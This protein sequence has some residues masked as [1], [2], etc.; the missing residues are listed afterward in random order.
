MS[1][2]TA[3]TMASSHTDLDTSKAAYSTACFLQRK[4]NLQME[5]S[6]A[7]QM[8]EFPCQFSVNGYE[9]HSWVTE[10]DAEV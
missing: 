5:K 3:G 9:N 8:E 2:R 10:N 6:N 1:N 4:D 7:N